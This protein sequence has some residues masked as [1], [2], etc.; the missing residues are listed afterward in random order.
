MW[1]SADMTR[2]AITASCGP[3]P[4]G[5]DF[6]GGRRVVRD[7]AERKPAPEW[8]R[9]R[10]GVAQILQF[11]GVAAPVE[12]RGEAPARAPGA[13]ARRVPPVLLRAAGGAGRRLDAGGRAGVA[14]APADELAV[15]ARPDLDPPVLARAALRRRHRRR[16]RPAAEAPAARD[17]ADDAR[18]PGPAA[19]RGRRDGPR[20]VLARRGARPPARLRQRLRPARA[21][22]V[23]DGPGR[24][25]RRGERGR[26]ELRRVQRRAHRGPRGGGRRDRALRRGAGVLREQRE[27][28]R[29]DRDA[30]EARVA[31][32]ARARGAC[33]D[34]GG[35][36]RGPPVRAPDE[37][38][39]RVMSLYT[40]VSGGI[41]P[42]GA[43]LV[44]T[45]SQWWGVSAAFFW[46][47]ALGL[48]ALAGIMLWWRLRDA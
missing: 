3:G 10:A 20:R 32:A 1:L 42:I 37:L 15:Q 7:V 44:G 21:P 31:R 4:R 36:R 9:P 47:G 11:P 8:Q 22:I 35:D 6:V 39:G 16:R 23:R 12:W 33:V 30:R 27:L 24:Q 40:W 5:R 48:A 41:F 26:A 46:N 28:P 29:G 13:R 43:F 2:S 17:H 14:R 45:I 34:A 38:R 19:R 18:L 25:G